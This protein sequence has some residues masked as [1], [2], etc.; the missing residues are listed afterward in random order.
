M[1][2]RQQDLIQPASFRLLIRLKVRAGFVTPLKNSFSL[3]LYLF[4]TI[5]GLSTITPTIRVWTHTHLRKVLT[6][7]ASFFHNQSSLFDSEKSR[8]R[9]CGGGPP[10]ALGVDIRHPWQTNS[11]YMKSVSGKPNVDEKMPVLLH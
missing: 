11:Y 2:A 6:I 4:A 10:Y 3:A 8:G 5:D 7:A 9:G 1:L